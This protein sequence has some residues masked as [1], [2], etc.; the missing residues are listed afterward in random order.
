MRL[1]FD[2]TLFRAWSAHP[3]IEALL[4]DEH[5]ELRRCAQCGCTYQVL[6][7]EN[8]EL[9]LLYGNTCKSESERISR[10]RFTDLARKGQEAIL[11]RLRFP[12]L[13]A[14]CVLDYGMGFGEW[15]TLA[16]AYGCEVWGSD[17][18]P[19][20][21]TY[22]QKHDIR[23]LAPDQIPENTFDFINSDQVFEHLAE[24]AAVMAHLAKALRPGGILKLSTPGDPKLRKKLKALVPLRREGLFHADLASVEP[25]I[26]INL[27]DAHALQTLGHG[28]G[29]RSWKPPLRLLWGSTS[30]LSPLRQWEYH[31]KNP[32][33]RW[34]QQ[35]TWQYF[36]KP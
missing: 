9:D 23:F 21:L 29:L 34:R 22:A 7:L 8:H 24:P 1:P 18:D 15:L 28:A 33:K 32:F 16:Q 17:V 14:P 2:A 13:K 20:S 26:H 4:K 36:I 30:V 35:G 6:V 12:H 31:L 19:A 27:F 10:I 5:Y 3:K 11:I 25:L